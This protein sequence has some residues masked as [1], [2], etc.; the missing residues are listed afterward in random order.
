MELAA[1]VTAVDAATRALGQTPI[2]GVG[3]DEFRDLLQRLKVASSRLEAQVGRLGSFIGT[4]AR[5]TAEWLGKETGTSTR[6]NRNA[7][8]LGQ[9]MADSD[10]LNEAVTN[11]DLS[12]D[13]ATIIVGA[14][15][16]K[17]VDTELL[18]EVTDLPLNAVRPAVENWRTRNDPA[19]DPDRGNPGRESS[20]VDASVRQLTLV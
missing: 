20:T 4:G 8:E 6:K 11:G 1:A 5:D 13:K 17:P 16:G 14:A 2:E 7:T 19:G 18:D 15:G 12:A 3:A 9:A 10:E